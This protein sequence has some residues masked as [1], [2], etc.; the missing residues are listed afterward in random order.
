MQNDV[1]VPGAAQA[2]QPEVIYNTP[3]PEIPAAPAAVPVAAAPVAAPQYANGGMPKK[4]FFD[5]I[6]T[7]DVIVGTGIIAALALTVYY[8]R[9]KIK[10]AKREYPE[11]KT[12][13]DDLKKK[14]DEM[15]PV[16]Q[17]GGTFPSY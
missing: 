7:M 8:F 9:E 5:G 11:L 1:P 13:I 15:Q 17:E 14:L 2:V 16:V 4:S 10:H 3:A 6:S 12:D